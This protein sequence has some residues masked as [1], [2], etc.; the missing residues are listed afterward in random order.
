MKLIIAG[1]RHFDE[2]FVY[3]EIVMLRINDNS[4][5][6]DAT[7]I[8]SGGCS[9]VDKAGEAY[10]EFY[11]VPVKRFMADWSKLGKSAG[12]IRNKKMAEYADAL[13]LVWDGR[14]RGSSNMKYEMQKL[15]KPVF[16]VIL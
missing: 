13:L 5:V 11:D 7:E 3:S 14:S 4:V 10:A 2:D 15:G 8:V 1:S 16:E 12:P 6:A 9:G